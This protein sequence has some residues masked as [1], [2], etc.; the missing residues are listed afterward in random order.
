MRLGREGG[1]NF[2]CGTRTAG[3]GGQDQ[4]LTAN[5]FTLAA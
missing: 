2:F 4:R 3:A 5:T 1:A